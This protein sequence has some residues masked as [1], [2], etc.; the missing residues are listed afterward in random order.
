MTLDGVQSGLRDGKDK[1]SPHS[2]NLFVLATLNQVDNSVVDVCPLSKEVSTC[3][4]ELTED[5]TA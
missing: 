3:S 2:V 4:T 1:R 5:L